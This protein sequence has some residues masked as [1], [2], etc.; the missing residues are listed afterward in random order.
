MKISFYFE[1]IKFVSII[2]LI[3]VFTILCWTTFSD[4]NE[5]LGG[6]AIRSFVSFKSGR[7]SLKDKRGRDESMAS[8]DF[9]MINFYM[10]LHIKAFFLESFYMGWDS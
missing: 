5:L 3:L 8:L 4:L 1:A 2:I 6:S 7:T 10:K 9:L